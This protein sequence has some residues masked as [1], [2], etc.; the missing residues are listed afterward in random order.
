MI[1]ILATLV[2][3]FIFQVLFYSWWWAM[4]IPLI[5]GFFEKDSVARASVGSGLGVFI[6]WAGMSI[7]Q[8]L[9]GGEI[10]VERITEVMGVSYGFVLV[11]ATSIVGFLVAALAG[12]AGFSLRKLLVKEYQVS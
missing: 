4:I 2:L 12:Y 5:L 3:V 10:I 7:F 1:S 6:L 9:T 8:W 11:L